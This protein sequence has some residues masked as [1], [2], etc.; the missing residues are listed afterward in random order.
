MAF[1]VIDEISDVGVKSLAL[2]GMKFWFVVEEVAR[3]IT[4]KNSGIIGKTSW[5]GKMIYEVSVLQSLND[6]SEPCSDF[7]L[8]VISFTNLFWGHWY[9]MGS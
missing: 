1:C 4:A 7:Y 5:G 8:L 9:L 3:Y 6:L 2:R